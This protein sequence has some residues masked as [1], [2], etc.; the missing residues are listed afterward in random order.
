MSLGYVLLTLAIYLLAVARL[1]RLVNYDIV[2]DWLAIKVSNLAQDEKRS[3]VEQE[4]WA[5]VL[6]FIGCPWCVGW[7][8]ALA[9]A[10]PTVWVLGWS[11]W[12]LV[13]I[14]LACSYLVGLAS[15]LSEDERTSQ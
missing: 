12:T 9:G 2:L 14:A 7:W 1:T 15:P 6:E 13:P 8:F 5:T 11:W 4:R 10:A 3:E